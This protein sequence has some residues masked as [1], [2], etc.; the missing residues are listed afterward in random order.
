MT[1]VEEVVQQKPAPRKTWR[2]PVGMNGRVVSQE[3]KRTA[4]K[5]QLVWYSFLI[6]PIL[7]LIIFTYIPMLNT[8]RYSFYDVSVLGFGE[9]F[10]GLRNYEMLLTN[11][12]FQR[13]IVNTFLLTLFS[14]LTIPLGFIL[15]SLINGLGRTRWQAFFRVAF[16]LPN[17]IT[18]VAVVLI[19]QVILRTNGGLLNDVLS[20]ILRRPITIGWLSDPTF[21]RFGVSM[22]A[23]WAG[24]G[25]SMLINLASLQSIESEIYEA[26]AID[27]AS[28][29][30]AW[31]H[32]TIPNMKQCFAF[33]FITQVIGG[34]ARFTDLFI[35]GGNSAAGSP[36]GVLQTMLMFIFSFSFETPQFGIASAGAMILFIFTLAITLINL[37]FTGFFKKGEKGR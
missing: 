10:V 24:L 32:I 31:W 22:L 7:T 34:L 14:L 3:A 13:S 25:Y 36:G 26:A 23:I 18:G 21:A 2:R 12:Q 16:Y 1:T 8:I 15:A 27:G 37:H 4:R 35:I 29:L 28:P 30:Q 33:L 20:F 9:Q 6:I 11:P 19:F 5:K 17:I